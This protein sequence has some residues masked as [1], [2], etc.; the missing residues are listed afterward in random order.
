M[1]R[2]GVVQG[3]E[4]LGV[5]MYALSALGKGLQVLFLK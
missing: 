4:M 2:W 1:G 5:F 3:V